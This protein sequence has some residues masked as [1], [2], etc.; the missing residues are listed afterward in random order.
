LVTACRANPTAPPGPG[1]PRRLPQPSSP[2]ADLTGE[3]QL[4]TYGIVAHVPEGW[5]AEAKHN[6]IIPA[7]A[8]ALHPK[9]H[10]D[11]GIWLLLDWMT[12]GGRQSASFPGGKEVDARPTKMIVAGAPRDGET[13]GAVFFRGDFT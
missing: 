4:P 1:E 13:S 3:L 8:W 11:Q 12:R 6:D 7:D 5:S 10:V 2:P 9:D